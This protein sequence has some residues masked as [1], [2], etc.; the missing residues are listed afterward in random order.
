MRKRAGHDE[1]SSAGLDGL[2]ELFGLPSPLP[3]I[4]FLAPLKRPMLR[5]WLFICGCMK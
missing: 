1:G 5:R 2:R 3:F 4:T